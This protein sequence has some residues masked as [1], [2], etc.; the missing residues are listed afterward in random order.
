M[1]VHSL[2]LM[3]ALSTTG[4]AFASP[5]AL[6]AC[7]MVA[8]CVTPPEDLGS[9][10]G[11]YSYGK[12]INADGTVVVG[13]GTHADFV[14]AGAFRW[15]ATTGM[16]DLNTLLANAAVDMT[17]IKLTIAAAVSTNSEFIVRSGFVAGVHAYLV[18]YADGTGTPLGGLTTQ[19]SIQQSINGLSDTHLNVMAQQVGFAAPLLGSG[20]PMDTGN[21]AGV[22]ASVGL[23]AGGGFARFNTG[24][25][26]SFLGGIS[27]AQ[28]R[29]SDAKLDHSVIG[30]LAA[31]YVY[32]AIPLIHPFA[33]LGG[34]AT[35]SPVPPS[36]ISSPMG[37]L[38]ATASTAASMSAL[39]CASNI[40][41]FA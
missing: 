21:K 36:S 33:E 31:Q 9:L 28:E 32:D 34:S 30:A 27:Y 3:V 5:P 41:Q 4:M 35:P 2:T 10:G 18:R 38:A 11:F 23:A 15:T 29:Y 24:H 19:T 14:T 6:A 20:Q 1:N 40:K 39:R 26:L 7:S 13:Y 22:F 12:G 16:A 17:G 37:S 25:G 8:P